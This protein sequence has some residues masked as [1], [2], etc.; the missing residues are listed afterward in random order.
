MLAARRMVRFA[1]RGR[2]K[3]VSA[4]KPGTVGVAGANVRKGKKQTTLAEAP[5]NTTANG[6]QHQQV[7][8]QGHQQVQPQ[9]HQQVQQQGQMQ[10]QQQGHQQVQQQGHQ[11]GQQQGHQQGQMQPP[12]GGDQAATAALTT[13]TFLV[14]GL[15]GS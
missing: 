2:W 9:G 8:Q 13:L 5:A 10:V 14:L 3:S 12:D 1:V 15:P 11:Q 7:H 6:Q 4:D